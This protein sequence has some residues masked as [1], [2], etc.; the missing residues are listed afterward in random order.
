M[1][2]IP[3]EYS[4]LPHFPSASKFDVV[5]HHNTPPLLAVVHAE[6]CFP[7]YLNGNW[8]TAPFA[9]PPRVWQPIEGFPV[10]VFARTRVRPRLWRV[11]CVMACDVCHGLVIIVLSTP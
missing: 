9:L 8:H 4:Q 3:V 10:V 7:L 11:A 5:A 6:Y 2:V 1:G